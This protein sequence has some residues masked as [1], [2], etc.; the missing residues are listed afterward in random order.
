MELYND[1]YFQNKFLGVIIWIAQKSIELTAT[2]TGFIYLLYS[3]KGKKQLWFYG[4]ITSALYVYVFY[5]SGIYADMGINLYYVVISIYGWIHWT[6]NDSKVK[7]EPE[8]SKT[9]KK[10]AFF[11]IGATGILF[12]II[13]YVLKNYTNSNIAVIDSLTTSASITATWM[14]A[15][16]KIEHW[17]IWIVIDFVSIG[18]YIYKGLYPTAVLFLLYTILAVV[19]YLEWKKQWKLQVENVLL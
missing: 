9:G 5:A 2:I 15:R 12:L 1:L 13:L 17:L 19:G 6:G 11:L 16:K 8:I 3:V 18:L 7:R 4:L 14:L 10:E